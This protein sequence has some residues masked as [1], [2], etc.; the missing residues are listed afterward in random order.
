MTAFE[1]L[2]AAAR[3]AIIKAY[4]DSLDLAMRRMSTAEA[5]RLL[6]G[7][8]IQT[9]ID[10]FSL[11]EADFIPLIDEFEN[12]VII[13]ATTYEPTGKG[14]R[15][16]PF[17]RRHFRAEEAVRAEG[18]RLV[19]D[20][21]EDSR[22]AVQQAVLRGLR[23][24]QAPT[25]VARDLAGTYNRATQRREGGIVGLSRVQ[26]HWSS[27]AQ[28]ELSNLDPN[29]LTRKLRDKRYDAAFKKALK[30]GKPLP[31]A[32]II[33]MTQ[34]YRDRLVRYRADTIARTETHTA[35][36]MGR[37]EK[38]IQTA[39]AAG[40]TANDIVA[41]WRA[42]QDGRTRDTH[43]RLRGQS[44]RLGQAFSSGGYR[45][46]Y[47]GDRS[48]GAPASEIVNCRCV[49]TFKMDPIE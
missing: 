43:G 3:K 2:S 4:F 34:R 30:D 27:V 32:D 29:Y 5:V 14:L 44:V 48:L 41:T 37:F 23:T 46:R 22:Q 16:V 45:M 1:D 31:T 20:L 40:L 42:S 24:G 35:L 21:T 33:R 9:L 12:T 28:E 17:N 7:Y 19:Q 38:I 26:E 36:N 6:Q 8:D 15:Q 11:S 13:A 47:P 10:Q 49:L 25:K 18:A 39:E